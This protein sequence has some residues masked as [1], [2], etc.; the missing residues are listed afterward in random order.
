M[1][2]ILLI[3]DDR[4]LA[5]LT[6]ITLTKNGYKVSMLHS[7]DNITEEINV[8]KPDLILMDI[9]M[10]GISGAEAVRNLKGNPLLKDIPVIFLTGLVL[11]GE[12]EIEK[13]GISVDGKMYQTLGKPYEIDELLALVS[14]TLKG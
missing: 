13:P 11:G 3:D 7:A 6:R 9:M 5:D 4:N 14:K 10:P 2:K 12:E 8:H 1:P